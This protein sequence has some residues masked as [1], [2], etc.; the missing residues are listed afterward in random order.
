MIEL[1]EE[2]FSEF[3]GLRKN[4]A[5]DWVKQKNWKPDFT[6]WVAIFS[7]EDDFNYD[8]EDGEESDW[9]EE[10]WS[11]APKPFWAA[12][13]FIPDTCLGFNIPGFY[14]CEEHKLSPK[15]KKTDCEQAFRKLGFQIV[16]NPVWGKPQ[17]IEETKVSVAKN[18]EENK[19][20]V[21]LEISKD[22]LDGQAKLCKNK[23]EAV[24]VFSKLLALNG[25]K[26]SPEHFEKQ[27][28]YV[29]EDRV[30]RMMEV[31]S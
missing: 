8:A 22:G 2:Q 21:V 5:G 13:G 18:V 10:V 27:R 17:E 19:A 24:K 20:W 6:K 7:A 14:E 4:K 12:N 11:V 28:V 23:A 31:S 3:Y 15:M 29:G 25:I 9:V 26:P 30:I 1:T 16:K